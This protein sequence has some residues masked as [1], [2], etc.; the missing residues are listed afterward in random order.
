MHRKGTEIS[1]DHIFRVTTMFEHVFNELNKRLNQEKMQI[2]SELT[3][4][5]IPSIRVEVEQHA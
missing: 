4:G 1:K 5:M 3:Q 2:F